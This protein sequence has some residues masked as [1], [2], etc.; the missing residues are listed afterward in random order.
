MA[1]SK[2]N[3]DHVVCDGKRDGLFECLHC[4]VT[5]DPKFPIDLKVMVKM[6]DEFVAAHVDCVKED[7]DEETEQECKTCGDEGYIEGGNICG[8]KGGCSDGMCGGCFASEPCPDCSSA[9]K[10]EPDWDAMREAKEDNRRG[11]EDA[12]DEVE[13]EAPE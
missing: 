8:S 7:E 13:W 6:I 9:D 5:Q 11:Y 10:Y 1:S 4:G 12:M 3:S 2:K